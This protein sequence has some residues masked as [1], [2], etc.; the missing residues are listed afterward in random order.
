VEVLQ[1]PQKGVSAPAAGSS[2]S[3]VLVQAATVYDVRPNP[4]S[5]GGTLLTLVVPTADAFGI[6][7]ASN[8]GLI[9]LVKVGG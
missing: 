2:A 4:S 7:Q 5:A 9:A 3:P 8:A 1:L 6:S